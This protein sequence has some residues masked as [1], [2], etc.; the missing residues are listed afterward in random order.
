MAVA[1]VDEGVALRNAGITMPVMVMNP[2]V[3]NYRTMF[4]HRLEPEVYSFDLLADIL[5]AARRC[6][7][8]DFPIHIKIDSGM[9]RLGFRIDDLDRLSAILHAPENIGVATAIDR[10]L[11][12]GRGRLSHGRRLYPP[13]V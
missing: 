6:G 2:K 13:A 10:V 4:A 12:S 11:T 5:D 3:A 8:H 7:E 1:V 9:H